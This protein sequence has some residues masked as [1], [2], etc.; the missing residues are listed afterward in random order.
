[1]SEK[2]SDGMLN[3]GLFGYWKTETKSFSFNCCFSGFGKRN[4]GE[5]WHRFFI[6]KALKEIQSTN[7]NLWPGFVLHLSANNRLLGFVAVVC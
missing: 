7:P 6:V 4:F 3:N 5:K 1:M 2:R